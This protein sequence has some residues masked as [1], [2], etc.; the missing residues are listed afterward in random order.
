[1]HLKIR[2]V[3]ECRLGMVSIRG[4]GIPTT[5]YVIVV[6]VAIGSLE[7]GSHMMP[8]EKGMQLLITSFKHGQ[9]VSMAPCIHRNGSYKRCLDTIGTMPATA[10]NT[11]EHAISNRT[12]VGTRTA[13]IHTKGV[14][15]KRIEHGS[16]G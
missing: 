12:P 7:C 6:V 16:T 14:A 9:D 10:L 3:K 8:F 11:Q 4:S 15:R 13:T 1:M 2:A 5:D